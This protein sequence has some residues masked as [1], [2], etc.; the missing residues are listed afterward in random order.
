MRQL[1]LL[2]T[3]SPLALI[4]LIAS[5]VGGDIST[6]DERVTHYAARWVMA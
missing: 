4:I 1:S 3:S 5:N 2:A 6:I